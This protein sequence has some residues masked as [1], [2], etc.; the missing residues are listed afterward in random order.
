MPSY[1]LD[2]NIL[3]DVAGAKRAGAFFE[4]AFEEVHL[5]LVTGILCISEFMAGAGPK[6]EAFLKSWIQSGELE[7]YPFDSVEDAILAGEM[8][9]KHKLALPDAI[10][11]VSAMRARCHLLTHDGLLLKK[12]KSF[13]AVLDPLGG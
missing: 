11:L 8:R 1:F 7:V 2:T 9:K 5:R 3:I 6:E 13:V 4:R 12:A 10:I